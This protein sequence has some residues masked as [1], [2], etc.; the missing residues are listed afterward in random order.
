MRLRCTKEDSGHV[1]IF[2]GFR[3]LDLSGLETAQPHESECWLRC[4][5]CSVAWTSD[6]AADTKAKLAKPLP[7]T[8]RLLSSRLVEA[9]AST[10]RQDSLRVVLLS[11]AA[12]HEDMEK[13]ALMHINAMYEDLSGPDDSSS[14]SVEQATSG[15]A[16]ARSASGCGAISPFA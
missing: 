13:L 7:I 8:G 9:I 5:K 6:E 14:C 10:M 15:V 2:D 12:T 1:C 16:R 3:P 11:P 4:D